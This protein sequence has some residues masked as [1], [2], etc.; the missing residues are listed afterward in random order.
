[1]KEQGNQKAVSKTLLAASVSQQ[2][3]PLAPRLLAKSGGSRLLADNRGSPSRSSIVNGTSERNRTL[4]DSSYD[5]Y[6]TYDEDE[7]SDKNDLGE[8][9]D[10]LDDYAEPLDKVIEGS[11]PIR[12]LGLCPKVVQS[13][14]D[15]DP[16]QLIQSD[17]RFDTDCATD[18]K[19]CE[20]ACGKRV[21]NKP[22]KGKIS[23]SVA[24]RCL[25]RHCLNFPIR[26]TR[27]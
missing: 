3:Q 16:S 2:V 14:A 4:D 10:Y 21:C 18:Q 26:R 27:K 15:C 22:L 13:I 9:D 20:A 1:M 5:D 17:C 23:C 11:Q 25:V 19:C 24:G 12:K 8:E 6:Y 7:T